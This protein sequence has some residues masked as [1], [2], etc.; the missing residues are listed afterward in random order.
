MA[1]EDTGYGFERQPYEL[2]V[3]WN[4]PNALSMFGTCDVLLGQA[5]GM[6]VN[7]TVAAKD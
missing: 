1:P 4:V 2:Y 5:E 3:Y 6:A 7:T